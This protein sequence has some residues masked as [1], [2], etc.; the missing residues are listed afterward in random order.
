MKKYYHI[1]SDG[2]TGNGLF[3]STADFIAAMN[4][5][6]ICAATCGIEILAF[7]FEDTHVHFII[8]PRFK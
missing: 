1:Y 6:A 2:A 7:V 8:Y 4:R 3:E 5:I